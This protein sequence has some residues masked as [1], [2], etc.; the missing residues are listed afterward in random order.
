MIF[1]FVCSFGQFFI[2]IFCI[3]N[4]NFYFVVCYNL[5]YVVSKAS[6]NQVNG[7]QFSNTVIRKIPKQIQHIVIC[8]IYLGIY[9]LLC[10]YLLIQ[11][12]KCRQYEL[13]LSSLHSL[14]LEIETINLTEERS[15]ERLK[16]GGDNES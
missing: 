14:V 5:K 6:W 2:I 10:T 16:K 13:S 12:Q 4:L 9:Y 1:S 3:N 8:I 15:V 11:Q 7:T